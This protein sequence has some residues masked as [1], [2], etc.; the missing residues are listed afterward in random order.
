MKR[1]LSVRASCSLKWVFQPARI[2]GSHRSIRNLAEIIE[3]RK[4]L[5]KTSRD[6]NTRIRINPKDKISLV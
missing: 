6:I 5:F 2:R 3:K 1:G 4:S